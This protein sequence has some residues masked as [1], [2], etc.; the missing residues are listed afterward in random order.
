LV[1]NPSS[2]YWISSSA[3]ASSDWGIVSPSAFVVFSLRGLQIDDQLEL[4]GLLDGQ[5]TANVTRE[6]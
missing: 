2:A 3:R 5:R 4:G 6:S 1:T